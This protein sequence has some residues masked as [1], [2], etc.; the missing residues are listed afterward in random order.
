M[1]RGENLLCTFIVVTACFLAAVC[2]PN[3][4][5]AMTVIGATSNPA[6]GFCL[7]II[8]WLKMDKSPKYSPKRVVAHLVNL[9]VILIGILSLVSFIITKVN[10][11]DS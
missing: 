7:P 11:S 8:Y 3:I 9:F 5:D 1:T 2:I 4:S 10:A 6:V